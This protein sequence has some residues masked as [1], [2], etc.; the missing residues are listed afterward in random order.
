MNYE[1]T[2]RCWRCA[3][4]HQPTL[5]CP[6]CQALQPLSPQI[7]YFSIL[8]VPRR[9][10][11]DEAALAQRYYDLSRRLHPDLYQI[12]TAEEK[13]ASVKN[14]ALLNRAYRTLRNLVQR[15][16][17]WLELQGEQL[18]K[19]NNR[20]PPALA[21][22][23]FEVQEKLAEIREA[24]A[25]G[26][27]TKQNAE[28]AQIRVELDDQMTDLRTALTNNLA[29]WDG[30]NCSAELLRDLKNLLSAI[31]YL[32]TLQRDV[33]KESETPWNV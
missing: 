21:A 3:D 20:V 10:V 6:V 22:L 23:V 27:D 14:T 12:G 19:D 13:E 1:A 11:V 15:G 29:R 26:R 5:F 17:Y 4:E 31:A 30:E 8:G 33:E 32:R 7:D 28:L 25:E 9:P 18:G 2:V 16:Q 24:R